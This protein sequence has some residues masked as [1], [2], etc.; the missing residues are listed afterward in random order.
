MIFL[1]KFFIHHTTGCVSYDCCFTNNAVERF[2]V[3]KNS[4]HIC[5]NR[6]PW[7]ET[8]QPTTP[9]WNTTTNYPELK[10]YSPLT[11]V[12]SCIQNTGLVPQ[13]K[14][15]HTVYPPAPNSQTKQTQR[16]QIWVQE[17]HLI[18][19]PQYA[20]NLVLSHIAIH[21]PHSFPMVA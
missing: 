11:W 6:L 1:W 4:N 5:Y 7:V 14:L 21:S 16:S 17:Q 9:S 2:S 8:L 20:I 10:H 12:W 15:S 18:T 13:D 19:V 3:L